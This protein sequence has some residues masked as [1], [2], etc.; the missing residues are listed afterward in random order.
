M[1]RKW[2]VG[3]GVIGCLGISAAGGSSLAA[4][5]DLA[6]VTATAPRARVGQ[7]ATVEVVFKVA[8]GS[9]ISPDAP[10]S[11]KFSGPE[12]VRIDRTTLHYRDGSTAGASGPVFQN[13]VTPL[14]A[15]THDVEIDASYY[16]CTAELCNRQTKT[17]HVKLTAK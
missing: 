8:E 16:V 13:P 6:R 14:A 7:P 5:S 15:G 9:H 1:V 2:M 17:L 4:E 10:L 3:A 12:T 11:L